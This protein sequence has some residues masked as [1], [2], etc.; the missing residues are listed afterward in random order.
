[1][2]ALSVR[3][4]RAA[5]PSRAAGV[6]RPT[7]ATASSPAR[8]AS[9]ARRHAAAEPCGIEQSRQD[10]ISLRRRRGQ[11]R[12]RA[13]ADA[14]PGFLRRAFVSGTTQARYRQ[15][16]DAAVAFSRR[17]APSRRNLQAWDELLVAW[18]EFLYLEGEQVYAAR[19]AVFGAIYLLDLPKKCA[20]TLPLAKATLKSFGRHAPERSR[21]PPPIEH[22]WLFAD[23][24]CRLCAPPVG[25]LAAA[26]TLLSFDC[27]LRPSEA[28][29]LKKADVTPARR[30]TAAR[31][32]ALTLAPATGRR[33]A[34]NFQ[35][36]T[37]VVVGHHERTWAVD[38]VKVLVRRA[39]ADTALLFDGLDLAALEEAYRAA[40]ADLK[41]CVVPHGMRHGG[42]S[43][44]SVVH[45]DELAQ[46]QTRGRWLATD[47]CRHYTKPAS[48]LRKLK[49][50]SDVQ[51]SLAR[52]LERE[53]PGRLTSLLS[54]RSRA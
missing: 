11:R 50:L 7:A 26:F 49:E 28:L 47:S 30:G 27:Y 53:L 54:K 20:Q 10:E 43:H 3:Q 36:D 24:L 33:T 23:T 9:A 5:A 41:V 34:K 42:P 31:R 12:R 35:F 8:E 52:R 1:M 15:A 40:S 2:Q 44:G 16:V 25:P 18:A 46:V 4:P 48:L 21:D 6:W 17:A 22:R 45:G 39:K 14:D 32:W 29:G 19:Y 13:A 51:V 38:I 37:G